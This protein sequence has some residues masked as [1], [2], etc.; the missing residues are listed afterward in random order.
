M[1]SIKD[2]GTG[3]LAL[4]TLTGNIQAYTMGVNDYV[5]ISG[6]FKHNWA[7]GTP[8]SHH[9]HIA[10]QGSDTTTRD[11]K[12]Q[13]EYTYVDIN[14][15][16]SSPVTVSMNQLINPNTPNGHHYY[17]ELGDGIPSLSGVSGH[18]I[19]R[20]TRITA[21]GTAPTNAPFVLTYGIHGY[22]DSF[23]SREEYSK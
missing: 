6:E 19:G 1:F 2:A 12:Y 23:G 17:I 4:A 22:V 10:T 20:I 3:A 8:I 13:L 11:V 16:I 9:L 14:G 18:V 5:P 15:N 7:L 21:V